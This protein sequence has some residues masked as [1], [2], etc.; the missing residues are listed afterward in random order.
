LWK[1]LGGVQAEI[2]S[3][4]SIGIQ[5]SPEQLIEKIDKEVSAGISASDQD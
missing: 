5:D 1:H 3:G 2:P 4:V